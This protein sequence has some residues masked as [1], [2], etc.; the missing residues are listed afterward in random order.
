[1]GEKESSERT[2]LANDRG[3]H[4]RS[5]DPPPVID[6]SP[7]SNSEPEAVVKTKTKSNQSND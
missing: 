5:G 2:T 3:E 4:L 6:P 7:G 1:M